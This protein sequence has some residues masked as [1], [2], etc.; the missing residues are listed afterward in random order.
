VYSVLMVHHPV[1]Q[2]SK[3]STIVV[4]INPIS[5]Y[6]MESGVHKLESKINLRTEDNKLVRIN[7]SAF[8]LIDSIYM[9]KKGRG[10]SLGLLYLH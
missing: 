3:E 2:S 8:A 7:D 6:V 10:V 1:R 9:R 4:E 5:P